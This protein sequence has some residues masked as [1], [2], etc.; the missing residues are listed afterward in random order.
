[1][2]K[3]ITNISLTLVTCSLFGFGLPS[4]PK[5]GGSDDSK[6]SG[7]GPSAEVAQEALV[8]DYSKAAASVLRAQQN[9]L[10]AFGNKDK[11]AALEVAANNL[12]SSDKPSKQEIADA[13][14]LSDE[15]ND[16]IKNLT[17]E[18][19]D[20]S[21]EGKAYYRAAIP[22][23][24]KG[25][26]GLVKLAN[27]AKDFIDNAQSEIKSAGLMGAAKLKKKLDA[28]LYVAPKIP[29]LVGDTTKNFKSLVSYGKKNKILDPNE[30]SESYLEDTDGPEL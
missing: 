16:E 22:Y 29:S 12:E 4:I 21:E 27:T 3:I 14:A 19:A 25:V 23:M 17:S 6:E 9:F 2:K 1:M 28:G 18:E 10:A 15:A 20:F 11:A 5:A 7:G 13:K 30:E 24:A 8:R 26:Q